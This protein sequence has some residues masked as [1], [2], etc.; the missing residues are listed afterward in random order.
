MPVIKWSNN[1]EEIDQVGLG[2]KLLKTKQIT[3][4]QKILTCMNINRVKQFFTVAL[5]HEILFHSIIKY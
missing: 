5:P 1:I 3:E 2:F 4:L